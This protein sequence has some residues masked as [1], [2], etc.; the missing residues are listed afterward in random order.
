VSGLELKDPTSLVSLNGFYGG[1][2]IAISIGKV[3]PIG[4]FNLNISLFTPKNV[5]VGA[6]ILP[7]STADCETESVTSTP[8]PGS[9][10]SSSPVPPDL[11]SEIEIINMDVD[12]DDAGMAI[13]G[14]K[15][16]AAF[17]DV[18]YD[19]EAYNADDDDGGFHDAEKYPDPYNDTYDEYYDDSAGK[20]VPIVRSEENYY[21]CNN[22]NYNKF[23]TENDDYNENELE[24]ENDSEGMKDFMASKSSYT[25]SSGSNIN[26]MDDRFPELIPVPKGSKT[27]L[28][29]DINEDVLYEGEASMFITYYTID[30]VADF[31]NRSMASRSSSDTANN[32]DSNNRTYSNRNSYE[33]DQHSSDENN[34]NKNTNES[35][36]DNNSTPSTSTST[37]I[38]TE[39]SCF[40]SFDG[41]RSLEILHGSTYLR[42][43]LLL[44]DTLNVSPCDFRLWVIGSVP[45]DE[46]T[47]NNINN[48]KP[49]QNNKDGNDNTNNDVIR[50][51]NEN[52]STNTSESTKNEITRCIDFTTSWNEI[53]QESVFYVEV[54]SGE[55]LIS[56]ES[57]DANFRCFRYD[58]SDWTSKLKNELRNYHNTQSYS[59]CNGYKPFETNFNVNY[60][61]EAFDKENKTTTPLAPFNENDAIF[62]CG[63]GSSNPPLYGKN[64]LSSR[65]RMNLTNEL[66]AISTEIVRLFGYYPTRI[67]S[68]SYLLFV[69]VFNPYMH[70]KTSAD[71]DAAM[72]SDTGA[73]ANGGMLSSESESVPGSAAI[74]EAVPVAVSIPY[75]VTVAVNPDSLGTDISADKD[76]ESKVSECYLPP[77]PPLYISS[78]ADGADA[79]SPALTLSTPSA[80][81]SATSAVEQC[82][83]DGQTPQSIHPP[84]S[85]TSSLPVSPTRHS[86]ALRSP[87]MTIGT[88]LVTPDAT[89]SQLLA[90]VDALISPHT[91]LFLP[92][93]LPSSGARK[94]VERERNGSSSGVTIQRSASRNGIDEKTVKNDTDI[95]QGIS[96]TAV[97]SF[98]DSLTYNCFRRGS[99][100][101]VECSKAAV[102]VM[103]DVFLSCTDFIRQVRT[104][105]FCICLSV[106]LSYTLYLSSAVFCP[107][108][109]LYSCAH[110]DLFCTSK[111]LLN[112]VLCREINLWI[113]SHRQ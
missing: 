24:N 110:V 100:H 44:S 1:I 71:A 51:S 86:P 52:T 69:K 32:I 14:G 111:S 6:I 11:D 36:D 112:I 33:N 9:S 37:S 26:N 80:L 46:N 59:V 96:D 92:F 53:V 39:A 2:N 28:I 65:T 72:G 62:G 10:L 19:L 97:A 50:N 113:I 13:N 3:T 29:S 67:P 5:R 30:N 85:D 21:R 102:E 34:E 8:P 63:L 61:E 94:A 99:A 90:L 70:A 20:T 95:P 98:K 57:F 64:S 83:T 49:H 17:G 12:S 7:E 101:S 42:V 106:C 74:P 105:S 47:N 78:I 4:F 16:T 93:P 15:A 31:S 66:D 103:S 22:G 38:P 48:K 35:S 60:T 27:A 55:R 40:I 58:E 87:L 88:I 43:Y 56:D 45:R 41:S 82:E 23:Y 76:K 75:P 91:D 108:L 104:S 18:T 25:L 107:S 109:S 68:K 84:H 54:L 79:L 73:G 81:Y 77:L 89:C